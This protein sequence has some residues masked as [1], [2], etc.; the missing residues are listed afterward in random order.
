MKSARL[1]ST[2]PSWPDSSPAAISARYRSGNWRGWRASAA[3]SEEP[4]STSVRMAAISSR[5]DCR[6][7]CSTSTFS[8]SATGNAAF[9]RLDSCRVSTDSSVCDS[10]RPNTEPAPGRARPDS[11]ACTFSATSPRAR[12]SWR[13]A[14]A[15][16]ASSTPDCSRPFGST[17]LYRKAAKASVPSRR[18][19]EPFPPRKLIARDAQDFLLRGQPGC[20]PA[21]RVR[22]QRHHPARLAG[23]ADLG[24]GGAA[25]YQRAQRV[26]KGQQLVD[27]GATLIAGL[28]ALRTA[29][30][31]KTPP[32]RI[33]LLAVRTQLADQALRQYSEQRGG[34][35]ERLDPHVD[36]SRDGRG[37][38]VRMQGGEHQVTGERRLHRDLGGLQVPDLA[39]HHD[40]RILPQDRAQRPRKRH[41]DLR[42]TWVC[43]I[44]SMSYS[45]GS[46]TV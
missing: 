1:D 35:Q 41:L 10:R 40:V 46:S 45:I 42:I 19:A 11:T 5:S 30:R 20:D 27:S 3:D 7:L 28:P 22:A 43:P 38:I 36:Q 8:A 23:R 24:V 26:V 29:G 25:M 15:L 12:S 32:R 13:A 33:G 2:A 6:S 9:S 18:C 34:E 39:D 21:H 37:R 17:A 44:P 16:S 14:R 4:P 31:N